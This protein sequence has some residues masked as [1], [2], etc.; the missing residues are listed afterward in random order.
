MRQLLDVSES[1]LEQI[2]FLLAKRGKPSAGIRIG[3]K[4]GGCSGMKYVIDRKSVV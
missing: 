1:A 3:T 2:R 4:A